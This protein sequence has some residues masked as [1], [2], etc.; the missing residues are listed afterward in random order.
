M[1]LALLTG[2]SKGLGL[3]LSEVLASRGYKVIEFSRTAPHE[4]SVPVD[5][6]SPQAAHRVVVK[7]LASVDPQQLNELLVINNAATLEPIGPTHRKTAV[8]IVANLNTNLISPVLFVSDVI[9]RFQA[10]PCRKVLANISAG[11]AHQ[12]LFGW[13]LYCAAKV[14]MEN[15]VHSLAIEQQGEP[16]PFIP[17][18]V[19][20]GV[21]DTVCIPTERDRGFRRMMTAES[22]DVDR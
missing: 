4:Y 22:D 3:A 12:G 15:F 11:V 6:S 16:C 13:S 17:V 5:L 7:T 21:I 10:I 20:P 1:H 14:A 9:A 18:S 8:S 2:G 19:D